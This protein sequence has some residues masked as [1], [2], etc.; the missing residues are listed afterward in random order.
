MC[1]LKVNPRLR[2]GNNSVYPLSHPAGTSYYFN[3]AVDSKVGL[4]D[5]TRSTED[6]VRERPQKALE[7]CLS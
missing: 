2:L 5:V 6:C 1:V 4:G 7:H 3:G